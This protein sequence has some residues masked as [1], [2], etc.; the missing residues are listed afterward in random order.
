MNM[1]V[2]VEGIEE[3]A[4]LEMI[5]SMGA[6]DVQGYLLGMPSTD[7]AVD[8]AHYLRGDKLSIHVMSDS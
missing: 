7:P 8:F 2:I 5:A 6:D 3:E 4:Q 1:R